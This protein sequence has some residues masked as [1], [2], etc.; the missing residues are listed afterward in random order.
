MVWLVEFFNEEVKEALDECPL[1]LRASFQRIVELIQSHGLEHVREPY[2]KHLEGPLW[3]I[4]M[5]G[6]SGIARA[7]YVTAVGKRIV[8]VHVF[9]K[10]TQKTHRREIETA[11][12]RAKEI[13]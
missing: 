10:K 13:Q 2:V 6:K 8:I 12:K 9:Q 1:D 5:K 4:R 3:E 11:L 7:I